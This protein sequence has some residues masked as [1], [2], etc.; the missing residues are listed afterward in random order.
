MS[1]QE[2]EQPQEQPDAPVGDP[3]ETPGQPQEEPEPQPDVTPET[4]ATPPSEDEQEIEA[5]YTKLERKAANY[6]KGVAELCEGTG[7][8]LTV[9]EMCKDAYAGLRWLEPRDEAHAAMIAVSGS[10]AAQSPLTE[11]PDAILCDRCNGFGWT[12]LPSK[13][14][15]NENRL[16]RK[17][18][19]AGWLDTNPQSGAPV[20]PV[21]A[22]ENGHSDELPG[23]PEN[24]PSVV[25]LRARGFTVIPPIQLTAPEQS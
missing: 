16:C 3:V 8:P 22:A 12:R 20:A 1:E 23:V 2:Q 14:P 21:P 17:C 9:C 19:G 24:D 13:V 7:I 5:L 25:D 15:G 18:N 6:F 4:P 11:D 10:D